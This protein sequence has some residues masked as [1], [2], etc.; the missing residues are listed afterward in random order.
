M[1]HVNRD[2]NEDMQTDFQFL[3]IHNALY[4]LIQSRDTESALYEGD[5][6]TYCKPNTIMTQLNWLWAH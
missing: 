6:F 2:F 5:I 4:T 3:K 1:T